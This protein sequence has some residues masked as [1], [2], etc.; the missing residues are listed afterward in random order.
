MS[1]KKASGACAQ[2]KG[3]QYVGVT[4]RPAKVRCGEHVGTATQ[5]CH[6]NTTKPV[7]AHF[8][9][10]G[11]NHSDL[12]FL[13]IEKVVSRD[14]FVLDARESYWIKKYNS[15]QLNSIE[16]IENGMNIKS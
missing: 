9:L 11:H 5:P 2:V 13:P 6:V 12:V 10:R 3:P 14:Q 4:T 15:V 16:T 1:C 7:G 8:R